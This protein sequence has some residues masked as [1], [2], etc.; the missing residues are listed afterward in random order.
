MPLII[1]NT[2]A[3]VLCRPLE[4]GAAIVM[5]STTKYIGGH[6]TSIGGVIVDG[7]NFDWEEHADALPDAQHARPQLSRRRLD[8][9][10]E[11]AGSRSPI[12]S[13]RASRC[14]AISAPPLRPFNAFLFIQGLETLP[15]R[16]REHAATPRR[17]PTTCTKHPKVTK[18][19]YP[20]HDDRRGASAAP[21]LI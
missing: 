20:G 1:D 4:H 9:G 3:P 6:G 14:C 5:H 13:R 17:S 11:A 18:V 16:I 2:A 10:G 21:T 7:G 8:P 19:I 12:S 15:L